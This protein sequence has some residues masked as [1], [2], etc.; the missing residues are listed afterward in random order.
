MDRG[1]LVNRDEPVVYYLSECV[2]V[3][4]TQAVIGPENGP[5][6]YMPLCRRVHQL[7]DTSFAIDEDAAIVYLLAVCKTVR[8][9]LLCDALYPWRSFWSAAG[10]FAFMLSKALRAHN[11]VECLSPAALYM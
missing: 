1:W 7:H 4:N 6:A 9:P 3:T 5:I 10:R 8:S 11:Y 2:H